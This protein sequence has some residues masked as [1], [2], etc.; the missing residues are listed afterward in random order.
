MKFYHYH[1][2][3]GARPIGV[4]LRGK[5]PINLVPLFRKVAR[6]RPDASRPSAC[7]KADPGVNRRCDALRASAF[8]L[9]SVSYAS[10]R[11][12]TGP[13]FMP[14]NRLSRRYSDHQSL[15]VATNE[16]IILVE[17]ST[18]PVI[19]VSPVSQVCLASSVLVSP[20]C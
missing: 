16:K 14:K 17:R 9:R 8:S 10:T 4:K 11:G 3:G 5:L 6:D 15:S 2:G 12:Q 19:R 7:A 18:S 20:F 13:A 1:A